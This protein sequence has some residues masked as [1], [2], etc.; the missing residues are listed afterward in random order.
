MLYFKEFL[1]NSSQTTIEVMARQEG[2]FDYAIVVTW[3]IAIFAVI[4]G[5][6]WASHEFKLKF[7]I[8]FIISLVETNCIINFSLNEKRNMSLISEYTRVN[9]EE[10]NET[11]E[12]INFENTYDNISAVEPEPEQTTNETLE[13]NTSFS[14]CSLIGILIL[15]VISNLLLLYFY[16]NYMSKRKILFN[17][18]SRDFIFI[19]KVYFVYILFTCG[20]TFSICR[21]VNFILSRPFFGKYK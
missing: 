13:G 18:F 15:F 5:S 6:L 17:Y 14:S 8:F 21:I 2:R 12:N 11:N 20:A 7:L 10:T 9:D 4:I 19:L 1:L 3:L 16:Y